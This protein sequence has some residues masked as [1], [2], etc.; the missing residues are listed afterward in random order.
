MNNT[1]LYPQ[2]SKYIKDDCDGD[3]E[4]D[5]DV[6]DYNNNNTNKDI[7]NN[8]DNKDKI[9]QV[10]TESKSKLMSINPNILCLKL[11]VKLI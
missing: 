10:I 6:D 7:N 5:G 8:Y 4:V 1:P 2:I 3:G 11:V 9:Q